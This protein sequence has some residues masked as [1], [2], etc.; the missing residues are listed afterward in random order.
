MPPQRRAA[1]PAT[2][3]TRAPRA[4][5]NRPPAKKQPARK[6]ER[7]GSADAKPTVAVVGAGR[8]GTALALALERCGYSIVALVSR[9]PAHARRAAGLLASRPV[10]LGAGELELL[11][12]SDILIIAVPDD[13]IGHVSVELYV[14]MSKATGRM[15][16][17]RVQKFIAEAKRRGVAV[18]PD[19]IARGVPRRRVALHVSGSLA[20]RALTPLQ[21]HGYSTGSLHPLVAVADAATGADALRGAFF[22]VEGEARAARVARSVVRDLGGESFSVAAKDKVLYHAAA[23]FA[24]GHAVALFDV[25]TRL[26][27]RCGVRE[28]L[29]RRALLSLSETA[30]KNLAGARDNAGAL[31][32]PFARGDRETVAAHIAALEDRGLRDA[33]RLYLELGRHSTLMTESRTTKGDGRML[34]VIERARERLEAGEGKGGAKIVDADD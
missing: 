27:A 3:T 5:K 33:L 16:E 8:V 28:R 2:E 10:A 26:L 4:K 17:A 19:D 24:A 7:R 6:S 23:V 21:L 1:K 25:A 34:D 20:S 12:P 15:L 30:L 13:Q 29:A 32:G 9:T 14:A 11:P 31:T 22:C 18:S